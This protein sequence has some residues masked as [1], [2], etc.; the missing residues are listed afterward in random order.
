MTSYGDFI[1]SSGR[2]TAIAAHRGAWRNAP[3]NSIGALEAAISMGCEIMETDVRRS[4]DGILFHLHDPTLDRMTGASGTAKDLPMSELRELRLRTRM[5]GSDAPE[6][7]QTIPTLDDLLEVAKGRIFLDLDVKHPWLFDDVGACVRRH[8]MQDQINLKSKLRTP[9]DLTA[10]QA[11]QASY[12]T[13]VMPQIHFCREDADMLFELMTQLGPPMVEAKFDFLETLASRASKFR[14]K[15]VSVWANTLDEVAC[16]GLDD[17][18]AL[19]DP[20]SVWGVLNNAGISI[21]QTD[22]PEALNRY[23]NGAAIVAE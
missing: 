13:L 20:E 1:R 3:E 22:E 6:T 10:L 18:K 16:C 12:C 11:L 8:R 19:L 5:G 21:I 17:S 15:G 23:L 7:C 14:S 4:R 9:E 2:R